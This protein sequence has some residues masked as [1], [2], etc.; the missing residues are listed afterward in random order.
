MPVRTTY[1]M[2]L[3]KKQAFCRFINLSEKSRH[4][5]VLGLVISSFILM[6]MNDIR[7]TIYVATFTGCLRR[8]RTSILLLTIFLIWYACSIV[9]I[10]GIISGKSRG[11]VHPVIDELYGGLL[12][13]EQRANKAESGT[14]PSNRP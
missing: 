2:Y 4:R 7:A 11:A 12:V 8:C 14:H 9:E 3:P 1:H 10:L 13:M 6:S 5:V